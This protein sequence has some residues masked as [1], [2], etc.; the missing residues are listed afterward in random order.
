MEVTVNDRDADQEELESSD[1]VT[2]VPKR[3]AELQ[4]S[5]Q[6]EPDGATRAASTSSGCE[7]EGRTMPAGFNGDK[8]GLGTAV[9]DRQTINVQV[10]LNAIG[11]MGKGAIQLANTFT[12]DYILEN[13]TS[14]SN[15]IIGDW[16]CGFPNVVMLSQ[17]SSSSTKP[18]YCKSIGKPTQFVPSAKSLETKWTCAPS[19]CRE[20]NDMRSVAKRGRTCRYHASAI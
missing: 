15:P 13:T 2:K 19:P 12:I 1:W 4:E 7:K 20:P 16:R 11:N 18:P 6:R 9:V 14:A 5:Q 8:H 17:V 3:V 10:Y